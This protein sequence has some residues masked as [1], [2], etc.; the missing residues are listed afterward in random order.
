MHPA[1]TGGGRGGRGRGGL[2]IRRARRR[3]LSRCHRG[4]L[5]WWVLL[6]HYY[7]RARDATT[8]SSEIRGS[9]PVSRSQSA[10]SAL[11]PPPPKTPVSIA[12]CGS[13]VDTQR[14]VVALRVGLACLVR[15]TTYVVSARVRRT[16]RRAAFAAGAEAVV[17]VG[18]A[19]DLGWLAAA[20]RIHVVP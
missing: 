20:P 11:T 9:E 15:R 1:N 10:D 6:L 2:E 19:A 14:A 3:P 18:R 16:A 8:P 13:L 7:Y 17:T 12:D 5:C 4:I